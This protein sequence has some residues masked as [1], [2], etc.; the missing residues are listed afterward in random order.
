MKKTKDPQLT[1]N[2]VQVIREKIIESMRVAYEDS[3]LAPGE[4]FYKAAN[5]IVDKVITNIQ[6]DLK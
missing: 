6:K 3:G 1:K 2:Q 5:I 4:N